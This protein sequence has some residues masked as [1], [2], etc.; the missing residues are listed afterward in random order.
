M[1]EKT[2][3]VILALAGSA[4][5]VQVL[6]SFQEPEAS[7]IAGI[8][9][10][11]AGP[12]GG[13][14]VRVQATNNYT[15]TS[16]DGSFVLGGLSTQA[17]LTVTAW[18]DGYWVGWT[19]ASPGASNILITL[20]RYYTS[21]NPEYD[22]VSTEGTEGSKSCGH[23]MP[24]VYA[25][26]EA[27][28]HSR[29]AV[30]PRFL[31][32]YTGADMHG[33]RSPLTRYGSSRDYGRFPL[34]PTPSEAY[35]GPGYL[36]DFPET[37][38]NC[39]ACHAPAA[40][41]KPG[42]AYAVHADK[43]SGIATEGVFCEFCHKIGDVTLDPATDLPY[44]NMPGVLSMRLHRPEKGEEL[45]FGPF[46]DVTRR[47]SYLPLQKQSAFCAP[48]HFGR[49]WG[50]QV[51]NSYG[52]WLVS[53]YSDPEKGKTCQD[54]HLPKTTNTT[55]ALPE[56][57][58][59][60]RPVGCILSHRMPGAD[61]VD[62]LQDTASLDMTAQRV[63]DRIKVDI[64]VTNERAG[65]HI[66]TDHPARNILLVVSATDARGEKLKCLSNQFIPDWGGK[67]DAPDD[68]AGRPGKGYAKILEELWT[69]ISPTAA[70]WRQIVLREDTRIPAL[71][72][73]VT[74]YE[75][76]APNDSGPITIA[77]KL[78]FRRAF[79][80]LAR[81]KK[82]NITDILMEERRIVVQ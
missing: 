7:S 80:E 68:Y 31:T 46:D 71:A 2:M 49:F 82:W 38:G 3:L 55:F 10:D 67:G 37:A 33:N 50:V 24:G 75:F 41:A 60:R 36:L 58:G 23:C 22:W 51:Y 18:A 70:Y 14:I 54:C 20:K 16:G 64:L 35:Y 56:K 11:E 61:N 76:D 79:K 19:K 5:L 40:A 9:Q 17:E 73:D 8:V 63:G 34:P 25:E 30:N 45:F 81:Q 28:A 57:G 62:L 77:A 52:E 53:P 65:H 44:D 32:M 74:H 6:L 69:E 43:I 59:V 78:I 12:V 1:I 13:A 29:S 48:C 15:T 66:P 42:Q 47:V 72:T 21:D 27:D 26:W 4:G 39:A